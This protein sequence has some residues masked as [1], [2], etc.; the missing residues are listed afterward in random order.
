MMKDSAT[1]SLKFIFLILAS[2]RKL[3]QS[4][5][6]YI[7]FV[8]PVVDLKMVLEELLGSMDLFRAQALCIYKATKIVVICEDGHFVLAAFQIKTQCLE[9]FD[10]SYKLAVVGL[11]S[12]LYKNHFS[13]KKCYRILLA[14]IGLSD[15][16]IRV[17]SRSQLT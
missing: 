5:C 13:Q 7:C 12:S 14:Q 11:I 17:S 16:S 15:Y 10:N 6:S 4:I 8:L 9:G 1:L 2:L 3:L